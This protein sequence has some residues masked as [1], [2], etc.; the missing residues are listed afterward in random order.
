MRQDSVEALHDSLAVHTPE[1]E[2]LKAWQCP[3]KP[4]WF[5]AIPRV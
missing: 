1:K 4:L 5:K 3:L 2:G